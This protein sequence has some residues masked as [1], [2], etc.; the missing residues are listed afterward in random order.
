M[1]AIIILLSLLT[2]ITIFGQTTKVLF[3]GNSITYFN[4]MPQTFA[5]ISKSHG[6]T[7]DLTVYAPGG[8]GFVNHVADPAV[9][10]HFRTGN[11]DYVILQ[12]GSNESPGFSFPIAITMQRARVLKDSIKKYSPCAKVLFYE[13]SY[14]VWGSSPTNV[15][16][17]N[18]T[19]VRIRKNLQLLSD[20]TKS[21]FAPAGDCIK[22]IWNRNPNEL[23]WGSAGDIHPN[24]NGSYIIACS[25]Y[26]S[27]FQRPS[28]GTSEISSLSQQTAVRYQHLVDSLVLDSLPK[29]RINTYKHKTE[30]SFTT[31]NATVN[32]QNM[33]VNIDSLRWDFGDGSSSILYNPSH[34][35]AQTGVYDVKLTSYSYGCMQSIK[36]NINIV[37]NNITDANNSLSTKAYPNPF[38]DYIIIDNIDNGIKNIE[39]YNI[40]GQDFSN[41]I[42]VEKLNNE[43][44]IN[45]TKLH[46]GIYFIK[47]GDKVIKMSKICI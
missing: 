23:L 38:S 44:K 47:V 3:I 41:Y 14:G 40:I 1:K 5:D 34:T 19:M 4:N 13:I 30:F 39:I 33:S 43:F 17:Y 9:Y 27:I 46:N 45:T 42:T 26:T 18:T 32:F 25:F 20:S 29:W 10:N 7:V 28:F 35:Y 16:T 12:P 22:K 15:N 31:N 2:S 8:T 24:I 6:D 36:N 21:F 37:V 11:W